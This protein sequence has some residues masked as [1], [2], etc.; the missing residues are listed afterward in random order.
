MVR[1]TASMIGVGMGLLVFAQRAEPFASRGLLTAS[2]SIGPGYMLHLP[3]ANIYVTGDVHY[4]LDDHISLCGAAAWYVD[5][6]EDDA[7][8]KQNS[9]VSFGPHYHLT[10]GRADLALGFMPGVS[11]TQLEPTASETGRTPLKV[12]PNATF[13]G[14][15]TLYVWKYLHFFVNVGYSHA[16]YPNASEGPLALNEVLL[17]GGLG[18]QLRMFKS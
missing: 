7:P 13:S 3:V 5:A 10:R 4:F 15:A 14:K 18:W 9:R 8:L 12:L 17:T 2:A 16:Q 11:L 1:T 6:Q